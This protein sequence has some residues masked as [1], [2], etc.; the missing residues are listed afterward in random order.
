[1][2]VGNIVRYWYLLVGEGAG[3]GE[4][5]P[6]DARRGKSQRYWASWSSIHANS[7]GCG[8]AGQG[9]SCDLASTSPAS[10][11]SHVGRTFIVVY[12][13]SIGGSS[14]PDRFPR[15]LSKQEPPLAREE[16]AN[17]TMY[18]SAGAVFGSSC[19]DHVTLPLEQLR[20]LS[21]VGVQVLY[22]VPRTKFALLPRARFWCHS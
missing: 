2:I 19:G 14:L 9:P 4:C 8:A 15:R 10:C 12:E 13:C 20:W 6:S 18:Q 3:A 5:G 1:V 11:P 7:G 21:S 22:T 17:H 16:L